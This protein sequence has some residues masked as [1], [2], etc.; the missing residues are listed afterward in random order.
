MELNRLGY[1]LLSTRKVAEA[2]EIFKLNVEIFPQ[3]SNVYD[4]LGEAYMLHGDKE[5]AIAN[6]KRSLELDPQ[7][8][9]ATAKLTT[10]TTERKEVKVDPKVYAS[11]AGEYELAAD[12]T[13]TVTTENGKLM[14]QATGQSRAMS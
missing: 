6:Y 3:A 12:F 4:S 8:K 13:I 9:N 5:L 1:R 11:Y 7:N 2:I 14:T 10:L